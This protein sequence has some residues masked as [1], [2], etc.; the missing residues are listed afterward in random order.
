L[1]EALEGEIT[2]ASR[3]QADDVWVVGVDPVKAPAS[4]WLYER[5]ERRLTLLYNSRPDLADAKLATMRPVEIRSRD[6]LTQVSYLTLPPAS[7]RDGARRPPAPLILLPHGGPWARDL[8]AYNPL[9]QFLANRGYA[10]LS[11]NFRGSTGFGKA[12]LAAGNREWGAAMHED[13]LDA[14]RWAI[15]EG[16]TTAD[17]VGILG[18]SYGGYC[19]LAA[20]TLTPT[21]FACGVD[22][23]GPSNLET[24]LATIPSYWEAMKIQLYERVGDPTTAEGQAL[25]KA[26]SPLTHADAIVRPLLIGQGAN[27]PRVKQAESDQIVAAMEARSIPVTYVL[28]PDEG[29]GFARPENN[30]AFFAATEHFLAANLGGR[31]E[32]FGEVLQGSSIT[33]PAGANFAPGLAGALTR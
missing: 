29:H 24:L 30:L 7:H 8:Y 18:G 19:V 23:V 32:P 12:H 14:V 6:G 26:R 9:H 10:V 27:D 28:F 33:V 2:I 1:R 25:L 22:I 11:P 17:Q 15:D 20:L 5:A 13:L 3:T 31:A 16:V 21:V 4:A